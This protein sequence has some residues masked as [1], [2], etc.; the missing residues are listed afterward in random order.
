MIRKLGLGENFLRISLHVQKYYLWIGVIK[1]N[2]VT[3]MLFIKWHAKNKRWQGIFS[4]RI[5][6]QEG[7][8][9]NDSRF[10]QIGG[11][12]NIGRMCWNEGWIEEEEY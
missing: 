6:A 12:Q 1:P 11:R 5:A 7:V 10:T 8:S 2:T 4:K 3:G 9:F